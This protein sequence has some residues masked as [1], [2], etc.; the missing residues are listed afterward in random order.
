MIDAQI[1]GIEVVE[2]IKYLGHQIHNTVKK[3]TAGVMKVATSTAARLSRLKAKGLNDHAREVLAASMIASI[4]RF[5]LV[6]LK[7]ANYIDDKFIDDVEVRYLMKVAG[8]TYNTVPFTT[9]AEHLAL[10]W[11]KQI[12]K[13]IIKKKLNK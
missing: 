7:A 1:L 12:S 6:P 10:N 4:L 9:I 11:K 5:Y 8:K 2:K 13:I 3:T